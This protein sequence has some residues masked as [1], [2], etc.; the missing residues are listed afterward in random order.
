MMTRNHALLLALGFSSLTACG[1][2]GSG[3]PL[4]ERSQPVIEGAASPEELGVDVH[5]LE[6][7]AVAGQVVQAYGSEYQGC[8]GTLVGDRV[9]VSAAHCVVMNQQ[10]W[11]EG[12]PPE[13]ADPSRLFYAFGEDVRTA[14]CKIG[15][16]SVQIHPNAITD[17]ADIKTDM[18]ITILSASPFDTCEGVMPLAIN[19]QP[20]TEDLAGE[21]FLQ[22]GFGSVDGTYDFSPVRYW[23]LIELFELRD[24]Y[25]P[26]LKAGHGMPTFG[27]SGSGLLRRDDAGRLH[28][29]GI[30]SQG[31]GNR[32]DFVSLE[33]NVEFFDSVV[34]ASLLCG[35]VTE[36]G[37][38]KGDA[39]VACDADGFHIVRDCADDGLGCAADADGAPQCACTC[40][41]DATCADGCACDADCPCACDTTES[42]EE[43]C[44]CDPDCTGAQPDADTTPTE[45]AGTTDPGTEEAP[46]GGDGGGCATTGPGAGSTSGWGLLLLMLC[47][48]SRRRRPLPR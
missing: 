8:S 41:T 37:M 6:R 26:M 46:A 9:V 33:H 30:A 32:L 42:C 29:Y 28:T 36:Q 2:A 1:S 19:R 4:A 13:I 38:C 17:A 48:A 34:N 39:I 35:N 24:G 44:S 3:E 5:P 22:G 11:F 12:Q 31:F 20:L 23:S 21:L 7:E 27:D 18:S 43:G 16:E 15:A 10:E 25:L 40:D 14:A 47:A 45:E